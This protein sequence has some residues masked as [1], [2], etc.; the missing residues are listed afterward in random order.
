MQDYIEPYITADAILDYYVETNKG[1]LSVSDIT[2]G[3][4]R[5]NIE[6]SNCMNA[7]ST[8]V[9]EGYL[10]HEEFVQ[11]Y[12]IL[13]VG[14]ILQSNGGYKSKFEKANKEEEESKIKK[15]YDSENARLQFENYPITKRNAK[16]AIL[17]SG[18]SVLI[19]ILSMILSKC[20]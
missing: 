4:G 3:L 12:H 9:S 15:W 6:Y 16:L 20:K 5:K 18:I 13:G 14:S 10:K 1:R 2:N 8:M 19:A 17:L 11:Y 7:L